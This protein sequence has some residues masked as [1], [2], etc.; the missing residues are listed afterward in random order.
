MVRAD[1]RALPQ[2]CELE[3]LIEKYNPHYNR[4]LKQYNR[5]EWAPLLTQPL[6]DGRPGFELV[7]HRQYPNDVTYDSADGLIAVLRTYSYVAKALS[8]EQAAA[9]EADVRALVARVHG[10]GVPFVLPTVCKAYMLRA[11]P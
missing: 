7:A 3:A 4:Q 9:L 1:S 10:E 2:V 8:E 5:E 6:G 11:P